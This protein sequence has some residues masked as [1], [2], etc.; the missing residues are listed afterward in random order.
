MDIVNQPRT[1][2]SDPVKDQGESR[3]QWVAITAGSAKRTAVTVLLLVVALWVGLWAFNA[4]SSFLFLLLLAWL[5]SIAMEPPVLLLTRYGWRRG[6]ATGV[7]ML[8]LLLLVAG[9]IALFG[10]L[11]VAQAA[12][13]NAQFPTVVKEV[14]DWVNSTFHTAF[15]ANQIQQAM[16]LT[17]Q[18][19]GDLAGRYGGGL[20]GVF[21]SLLTFI[22]DAATILVF[23]YY[24]SA[25]S[26]RLRQTIGSWLPPRYQRVVITV[27]TIAVEKAGGYVISKVVLASLSATAHVLF[28]WSINVPSWL[29]LGVLAGIVGQFIPT[30]G[31]YIGVLLPASFALLDSPIKALWIALFAV[32]YQQVENYVFTPKISERTMDVHP[33]I[34]LGS[35]FAGASLFGA[36]GAV[37]GIPVAAALLTIIDTF[38]RRHQLL[39]E[40]ADL[41]EQ[42]D[43]EPAGDEARKASDDSAV[44]SEEVASGHGPGAPASPA[45]RDGP[46]PPPEAA[47]DIR[48]S[49][50]VRAQAA[51][52]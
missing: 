4:L 30:I 47:Q 46:D 7:V 26:P 40:L 25:D 15:D 20:L 19:L 39:P 21:G 38:R 17:P 32:V 13:L 41:K 31:T 9:T 49:T 42:P 51:G 34:A 5:L 11:F 36:I 27:W 22:F 33:A 45:R 14:I 52:S 35:V 3:P 44:G 28:F 10:Q 37:I 18:Q 23:T 50:Q 2:R 8:G 48:E 1:P 24:L 43:E 12:Q 6:L 29:P 16:Q